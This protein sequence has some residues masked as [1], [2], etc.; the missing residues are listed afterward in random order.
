MNLESSEKNDVVLANKSVTVKKMS[1]KQN[2]DY[3]LKEN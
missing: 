3:D 1:E 2:E